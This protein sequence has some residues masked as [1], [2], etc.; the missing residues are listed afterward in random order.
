MQRH[1]ERASI[2]DDGEKRYSSATDSFGRNPH[3]SWGWMGIRAL[4]E[5]MDMGSHRG[6][7]GKEVESVSHARSRLRGRSAGESRLAD[8]SRLEASQQ[9][10]RVAVHSFVSFTSSLG[11][12]CARMFVNCQLGGEDKNWNRSKRKRQTAR[13]RYSCKVVPIY[14]NI[15]AGVAYA[16]Q[17][18]AWMF[19]LHTTT[20]QKSEISPRTLLP[21]ALTKEVTNPSH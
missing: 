17:V 4:G 14:L 6:L 2:H 19:H 21:P 15:P 1:D 7:G 9:L 10:A 20:I 11:V 12:T 18:Y 16:I 8:Q 5:G 3:G 13:D